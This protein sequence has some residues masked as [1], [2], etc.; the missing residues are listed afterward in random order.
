MATVGSVACEDVDIIKYV[1][2]MKYV[3]IVMII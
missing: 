2:I 3:D 1:D